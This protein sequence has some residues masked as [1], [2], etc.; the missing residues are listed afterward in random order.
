MYVYVW[1]H[2]LCPDM[3]QKKQEGSDGGPDWCWKDHNTLHLEAQREHP[4]S[5]ANVRSERGEHTAGEG[6]GIVGHG[7]TVPTVEALP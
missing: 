5:D 3:S 6:A 7:R 2:G 1:R 4:L